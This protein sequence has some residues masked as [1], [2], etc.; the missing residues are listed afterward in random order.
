MNEELVIVNDC[1]ICNKLSLYMDKKKSVI[2]HEY[3]VLGFVFS[4]ID[5]DFFFMSEEYHWESQFS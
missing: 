5:P 4:P 2:Y 3:A 1:I